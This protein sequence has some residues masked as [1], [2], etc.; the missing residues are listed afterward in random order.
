MANDL[1]TGTLDILI[2]KAVTWGPRHGYAIG[3]WIRETTEDVLA[4][5]EGVLYP[6]LHR[7][8]R[9]GLLS[10]EWDTTD[11]G[12][13]AKFYTLTREGRA[14]LKAEVT[15]WTRFTRAVNVAISMTS[16]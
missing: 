4:V 14:H 5:Q 8:E 9:R 11:T 2:L 12:R 13:Q 15:R 16:A 1:F 3:R 6:A 10:E 7:L